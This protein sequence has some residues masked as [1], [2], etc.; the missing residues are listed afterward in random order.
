[1]TGIM[2]NSKNQPP[3]ANDNHNAP[4][5]IN[6]HPHVF[7]ITPKHPALLDGTSTFQLQLWDGC[8]RAGNRIKVHVEA[9]PGRGGDQVRR[10]TV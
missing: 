4:Q 8:V 1:M 5:V 7:E 10:P 3:S 2:Q 9:F 6:T